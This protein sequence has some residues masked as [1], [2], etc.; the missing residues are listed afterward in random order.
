MC[1]PTSPVMLSSIKIL[2][3]GDHDE[4]QLL[5]SHLESVNVRD[6]NNNTLLHHACMLGNVKAARQLVDAGLHVDQCNSVGHTPLCDAALSGSTE[7]VAFLLRHGARADPPSYW[8]S[9]LTY[10]THNSKSI[11]GP[12]TLC[13]TFGGYEAADRCW[14]RCESAKQTR[15]M[16]VAYHHPKRIPRRNESTVARRYVVCEFFKEPVCVYVRYFSCPQLCSTVRC[17]F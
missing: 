4:L 13:R 9:P 16:P 17:D 7:L 3:G 12:V 10:A 15:L 6:T 11:H 1:A 8:G 2:E 14:S 5:M